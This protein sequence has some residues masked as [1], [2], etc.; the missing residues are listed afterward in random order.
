MAFA[1]KLN[2]SLCFGPKKFLP[3]GVL[4]MSWL[5]DEADDDK[6]KEHREEVLRRSQYW[7]SIVERLGQQVEAI[8]QHEHWKKN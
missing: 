2:L 5:D 8:N 3:R 6:R 4:R 1:F 7:A